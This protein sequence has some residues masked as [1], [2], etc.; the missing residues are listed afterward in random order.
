MPEAMP[1]MGQPTVD[2]IDDTH[3][4][5][6]SKYFIRTHPTQAEFKKMIFFLSRWARL[7]EGV[8]DI[9]FLCFFY[10]N[11]WTT[12]LNASNGSGH[13]EVLHAK[14]RYR[15]T[16]EITWCRQTSTQTFVSVFLMLH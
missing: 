12:C 16:S 8:L 9:V 7:L 10:K 14:F 1:I 3:F 5:N 15:T 13:L 6:I 11:T 2:R 4:F